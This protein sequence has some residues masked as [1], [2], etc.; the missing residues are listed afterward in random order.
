MNNNKNINLV[1]KKIFSNKIHERPFPVLIVRNFL[2]KKIFND[3]SKALPSYNDLNGGNIFIQSKSGSKR[4]VF[5]ESDYFKKKMKKEKAIKNTINIFKKIEPAINKKFR[6]HIDNN[7]NKFFINKKTNFSCSFSSCIK[8]YIKS[9]HID[10]REH[11]FHIL[12]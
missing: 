10:R 2:P 7:I 1:K 3:L 6:Q 12:Y 4:S 9:A 11:K 8:S 5:I